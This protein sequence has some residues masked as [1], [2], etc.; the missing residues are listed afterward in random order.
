MMMF[1]KNCWYVAA[2]DYELIDGKLLNRTLLGEHVLLYRGESGTVIAMNDRCPHRGALLSKGRLEGDSVRCMYHGIKYDGS[3]KCVQIPGQEMI[4]PKLKVRTYPVVER[5]HF[6]WVWM[7]DAARADPALILDLPY[8]DDPNWKGIPA[9]LHYD[10]NYLLIVDNLSDFSHL[11]FVH[12][13]TLGGSEEYAFVTKPTVVERLE[14][15]F[16]VERWHLNSDPPPFHK[17]VIREK[18]QQVD[19]RNIATMVIPGIF[20]METLF[21]PAGRG[22]GKGDL[23]DA[24][25]Y[26]NCQFMTPETDRT[27]HFF[28]SYLNNFER[29]DSTISRSLLDSLIEGF[30]EDKEII[31]RQ[32]RTL[33]EDPG[34]QMLGILA[35]APLAH[36]RRLLDKLIAAEQA[37]AAAPPAGQ[38]LT[39]SGSTA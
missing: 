17:K 15:G 4:P 3:G 14:R 21:A 2:L 32:Q 25:E 26:R 29:G 24:K 5:S 11:A 37:G 20:T 28:W 33:E 1:L 31:E 23:A 19:R 18:T 34:F 35:D 22:A 16:R 12:T 6:I 27:T 30:M 10:A 39:G 7:G 13:K 9:Y 8:L 36:F 38:R